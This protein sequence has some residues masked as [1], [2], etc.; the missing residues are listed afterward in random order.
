MN[1]YSSDSH[2]CQGR[3]EVSG[4]VT[5]NS[6]PSESTTGRA[7]AHEDPAATE[8]KLRE[9]ACAQI[10]EI[11]KY[12]WYLGERLGRDPL[13]DRTKEEICAEWIAKHAAAFRAWWET[14]R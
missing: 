3:S 7:T 10:K 2:I 14:T 9:S 6:L 12:R 8:W 11:E 4:H 13:L 1:E 5:G